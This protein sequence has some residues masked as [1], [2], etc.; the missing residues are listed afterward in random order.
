MGEVIT[1]GGTPR[2]GPPARSQREM[3]KGAAMPANFQF[4][5]ALDCETAGVQ[6]NI[7]LRLQPGAEGAAEARACRAG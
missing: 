4:E 7:A 6:F 3:R 1:T 2:A 5:T